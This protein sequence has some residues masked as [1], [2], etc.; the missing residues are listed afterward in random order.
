MVQYI[1]DVWEKYVFVM[2]ISRFCT[3]YGQFLKYAVILTDVPRKQREH[4]GPALSIQGKKIQNN[5]IRFTSK[6]T[7]NVCKNINQKHIVHMKNIRHH[8]STIRLLL[9]LAYNKTKHSTVYKTRR[10]Y[11]SKQKL[12]K[13]GLL[14]IYLLLIYQ[15]V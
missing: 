14:I 11:N 7:I 9:L 13:I 3:Q 2:Q 12:I 10:W 1:D 4:G 5:I 8:T 15:S 6:R